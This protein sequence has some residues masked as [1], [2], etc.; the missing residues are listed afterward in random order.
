MVQSKILLENDRVKIVE[1]KVAP[2]EKMPMHTHGAYVA[3]TMNTA[4][5]RVVLPDGTVR[6]QE[7]EKGTARYSD[8]VTHSLENIGS[9]EI[10]NLD[11]ELKEPKS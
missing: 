9:T 10:F 6:E 1:M 11:I 5:I 2:G 7:I 8:G 3:Y 4:K